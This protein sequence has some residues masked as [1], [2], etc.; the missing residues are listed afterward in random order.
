MFCT[1]TDMKTVLI[2]D[3]KEEIRLVVKTTLTQFGFAT[4]E[5]GDGQEG[6]EMALMHLPDLIIC[7]VNMSGMDG[8]STLEAIRGL[9]LFATTPV[10]LMTGTVGSEEFRRGMSSG[11]DDFLQKPFLPD[12]LVQAVVSRLV[13]HAELQAE[14]ERRARHMRDEAVQL[15]SEELTVPIKDILGAVSTLRRESPS[16]DTEQVFANACRIKE[17]VMRMGQLTASHS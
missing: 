12:E 10:I 7:D 16:L 11:A 15:L 17:S 1:H 6:V 2:I 5:A 8:F 4:Y 9:T 14:V 13:R 3:D